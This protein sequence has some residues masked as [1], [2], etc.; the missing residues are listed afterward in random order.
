MF[1]VT[2]REG[3]DHPFQPT[4]HA[5]ATEKHAVCQQVIATI[6]AG[7]SG[8]D[9]RKTLGGSPFGWPRDAVDQFILAKLN[10]EGPTPE[11]FT[12]KARFPQPDKLGGP[13][14]MQPEPYCVGWE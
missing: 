10:A 4:G 8:S 13:E 9:V 11:A 6:G 7:K 12:F 14:D 3:A 1:P 5:D 2:A